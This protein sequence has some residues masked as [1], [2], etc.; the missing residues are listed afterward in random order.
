MF[1]SLFFFVLQK[2]NFPINYTI[3]VHHNEIF[4]LSNISRMV[5]VMILLIVD[6][7]SCPVRGHGEEDSSD[8]Y[9]HMILLHVTD[10][11]NLIYLL[12]PSTHQ[13]LQVEELDELVLQRLWFQVN[14][15]VLKKVGIK[16]M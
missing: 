7:F 14:Q 2:H 16:F 15:G 10:L 9:C 4:R 1:L 3:R 11:H 5:K 8:D 13:R 12:L 6:S